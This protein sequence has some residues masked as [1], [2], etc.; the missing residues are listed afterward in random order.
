ME[1]VL[2]E[3]L[4]GLLNSQVPSDIS[5]LEHATEIDGYRYHIAERLVEE[6]KKLTEEESRHKMLKSKTYT[7]YDR[8]MYTSSMTKEQRAIVE[9]LEATVQCIDKRINL[10]QSM[11]RFEVESFKRSG[12]GRIG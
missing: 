2:P 11:L 8:K 3:K 5:M 12:D 9:L 7:E 1:D 6:R 4:R 10:I